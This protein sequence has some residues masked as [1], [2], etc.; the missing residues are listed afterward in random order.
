MSPGSKT[1]T[2]GAGCKR[3]R[4][5]FNS[6]VCHPARICDI[7]MYIEAKHPGYRFKY[8]LTV[9]QF[10][11]PNGNSQEQKAIFRSG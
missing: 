2:R 5:D 10:Y 1:S 6:R 7:A 3:R 8:G 11:W 4:G 9:M